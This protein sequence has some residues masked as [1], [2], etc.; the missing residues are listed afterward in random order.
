MEL[1]DAIAKRRSIRRY[2][3][4]TVPEE[5]IR[6]VL[7]AARLAPSWANTQC[8]HF[9]VVTDDQVKAKLAEAGM[10]FVAR[11]P[12]V[13]VGCAD[14]EKPGAKGDMPNYLVDVGIAMEHLMLAATDRGLGTCWVGGFNEEVAR[15]A[16]GAP[17]SMRVVAMTP[18]GYPDE[19]PAPRSRKLLEE[20]V[21]YNHFSGE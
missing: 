14:P 17:E 10:R 19:D 21:S 8:W 6:Y 18:L 20:I 4:D 13:I 11:A 1:M 3:P 7:E 12:V 15:A 2:K 16:I 9:V 5:E